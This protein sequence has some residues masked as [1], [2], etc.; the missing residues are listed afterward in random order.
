MTFLTD[1]SNSSV[2]SILEGRDVLA[3]MGVRKVCSTSEE[4]SNETELRHCKGNGEMSHTYSKRQFQ[5]RICCEI[6]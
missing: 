6:W 3:V 4:E 5:E 1:S 2:G